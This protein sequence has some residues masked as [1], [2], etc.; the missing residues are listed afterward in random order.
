MLEKEEL[1]NRIIEID[2]KAKEQIGKEKDKSI[3][4]LEYV[5]DEFAQ[6]KEKMDEEYK[7]KLDNE[8]KKYA[9]MFLVE[10]KKIDEEMKKE[11][12]EITKKYKENEKKLIEENFEKIKAGEE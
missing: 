5:N 9:D 3:N 11:L 12:D 1:I 7:T 4:M 8:K 2:N 10:K 6:K